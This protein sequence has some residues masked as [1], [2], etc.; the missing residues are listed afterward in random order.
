M[1]TGNIRLILKGSQPY[2]LDM[3]T[4]VVGAYVADCFQSVSEKR[5]LPHR[6]DVCVHLPRLT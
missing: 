3:Y 4:D 6:C 5:C 1:Q 2:T